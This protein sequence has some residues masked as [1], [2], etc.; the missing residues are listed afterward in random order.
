MQQ[1]RIKLLRFP[2]TYCFGQPGIFICTC[3]SGNTF[4]AQ[5]EIEKSL[6]KNNNAIV[7]YISNTVFT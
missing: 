6:Q 3:L 4:P 7:L 2:V 1:K 5:K